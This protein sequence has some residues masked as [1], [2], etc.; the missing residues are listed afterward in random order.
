MSAQNAMGLL[1][2]P[3]G[4][5]LVSLLVAGE[6]R[7]ELRSQAAAMPRLRLSERS[8]C[9]LE[10]LAIGAFSP[11]ERFISRADYRSILE[12]M[13]LADRTL[14]PIPVTLPVNND[15]GLKLDREVA[16]ADQHNNLLAV[17]RIEEIFHWDR[18]EEASRIY[19]TT[20]SR[21]PLVAEM[22]SWG[23][24]YISGR[25]RVLNLPQHYDFKSL[26]LNPLE[27]RARLSAF[28]YS[29]VVAFQTRNPLHRAHEE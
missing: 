17:M 25:L 3:Y 5:R 10:L 2:N 26:R 4:G 9:D 28:G 15:A 18:S 1:I 6:E 7:E 29:K 20:D 13:R 24:L 12:E 11:L 21:H 22:N 19:G 8:I 23:E 27:V 14:F 16:L